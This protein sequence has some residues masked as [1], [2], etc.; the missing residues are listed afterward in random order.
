MIQQQ[1]NR[2]LELT[3]EDPK[4]I[5]RDLPPSKSHSNTPCTV[6]YVKD[7]QPQGLK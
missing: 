5:D 3:A 7:N 4:T 6:R 2:S 1:P